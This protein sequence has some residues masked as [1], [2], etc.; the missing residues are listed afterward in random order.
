MARRKENNYKCFLGWLKWGKK[1]YN[2]FL[3]FYDGF[4]KKTRITI[5]FLDL[6]MAKKIYKL[7][8]FANLHNGNKHHAPIA[9]L[10]HS[11]T[12]PC[13][14]QQVVGPNIKFYGALQ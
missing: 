7:F 14:L 4:K 12:E 5:I 9:N 10:C 8:S 11:S 6:A 1:N 2:H 13:I 3:G